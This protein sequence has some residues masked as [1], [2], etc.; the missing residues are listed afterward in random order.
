MISKA[1]DYPFYRLIITSILEIKYS[2]NKLETLF[3]D[4]KKQ[5]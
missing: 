3:C 1:I 2:S 4:F 5:I